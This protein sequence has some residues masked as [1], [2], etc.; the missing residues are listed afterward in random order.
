MKN[1]AQILKVLALIWVALFICHCT[2]MEVDERSPSSVPPMV[3][4]PEKVKVTGYLSEP[5]VIEGYLVTMHFIKNEQ[6]MWY[7][8]F[9]C[10]KNPEQKHT[11]E[12][13]FKPY[14]QPSD[15]EQTVDTAQLKDSQSFENKE[16]CDQAFSRMTQASA[17][18]PVCLL[19]DQNGFLV[20]ECPQ[21]LPRKYREAR[22]RL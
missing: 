10:S 5:K 11:F 22:G 15:L 14:L 2:S 9:G 3:G 21:N 6:E 4:M 7:F 18:K 20:S 19:N 12:V 13:Y 8:T 16:S 1:P 17:E